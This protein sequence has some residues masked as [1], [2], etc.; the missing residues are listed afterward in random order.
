MHQRDLLWRQSK[1]PYRVWLSEIMLQQTR[2]E[3]ATP[4]FERFLVRF[5]SVESLAAAALEDVLTEW[6]G[7]GYYR[8][9]RQLH[10]AAK[11]IASEGFPTSA[12]ELLKLPGVGQYTAA[13]VASI[14]FGEAIAVLDGNVER[15]I[16]RIRAIEGHPKK[17]A[18]RRQLQSGAQDFVDS[19]R[20][21]DSNQ[22]LMEL[23]A[24]LCLPKNPK[25]LICPLH[26]DC[27]ARQTGEVERY[28]TPTK[29]K[30]Q[31]RV[32]RTAAALEFDGRWLLMRRSDDESLLPGTWE[33]PWVS[34]EG[35]SES[36][37]TERDAL[38]RAFGARYGSCWSLGEHLVSV[39][40]SITHRAIEVRLR[41]ASIG[42]EDEIRESVGRNEVAWM[43]M[44]DLAERPHSSLTKKLLKRL[45]KKVSAAK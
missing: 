26:E 9:A 38:E 7:L 13:A 25:C 1:D 14:A 41:S 33:L 35:E 5:P 37:G 20:A 17:A 19:H 43:T 32:V 40:H 29:K 21:G 36:V 23:G 10:A 27:K 34:E 4:Y 16:S 12:N 2:V 42:T 44:S 22:A 24:T 39:K 11:V 28:P 6:S 30:A 45:E 8:R 15:V 18:T 3:T 31:Q